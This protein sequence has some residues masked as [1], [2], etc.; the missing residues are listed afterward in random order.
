[1]KTKKLS[2]RSY[3]KITPENFH[4]NGL[5][6]YYENNNFYRLPVTQKYDEGLT[7]LTKFPA[8]AY[9]DFTTNSSSVGVNVTLRDKSYMPHMTATG[10]IGLDLYVKVDDKYVFMGT[11]KLDEA[12]FTY[13]YFKGIPKVYKEYRLYFPI[14]MELIELELIL[15]KG[16]KIRQEERIKKQPKLVVYGTSIAQ[17]GCVTRPGMSYPAILGRLLPEY[18]VFNLGFSGNALLH[19]EIANLISDVEDLKVLV[20]EVEANAGEV[21]STLQDRLEDFIKT[22]L[23]KNPKLKIYLISHFPYSH[24]LFKPNLKAKH[25]K[26]KLFQEEVCNKYPKNITFID[27][28]EILKDLDYEET[29]DL[30]HLT[31]LGC[32]HLAKRLAK[33]ISKK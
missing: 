19:P 12:E 4:V 25:L 26:H 31:D 28:E 7:R 29:V 16:A 20:M 2:T 5:L 33:Q 9:L 10:T 30:I 15:D 3:Y 6:Y 13:E 18:E 23:D 8:G 27:G 24:T 17:G 14:Y 22:I 32:Y 1:M 11:T 21:A